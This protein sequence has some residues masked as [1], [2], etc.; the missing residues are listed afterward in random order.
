MSIERY[1]FEVEFM[2][3]KHGTRHII[4]VIVP[5]PEW[6]SG[7]AMAKRQA[8]KIFENDLYIKY[9]GQELLSDYSLLSAVSKGLFTLQE[10]LS[11]QEPDLLQ[12]P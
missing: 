11:L 10:E 4:K 9:H 7:E 12:E 3:N 6:S 8:M 2:H 1:L 5:G